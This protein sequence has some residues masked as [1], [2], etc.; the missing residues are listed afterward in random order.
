[1]QAEEDCLL[2]EH[3]ALSQEL[4][5]RDMAAYKANWLAPQPARRKQARKPVLSMLAKTTWDTS[6]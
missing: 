6:P 2:A 3:S 5:A 4:V 1:M